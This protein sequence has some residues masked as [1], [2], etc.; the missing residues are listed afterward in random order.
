M[1]PRSAPRWGRPAFVLLWGLLI[2]CGLGASPWQ[3]FT[4]LALSPDGQSF[5]TGGREGEVL[6]W[7]TSTG[8]LLYRWLQPHEGPVIGLAFNAAGSQLGVALLD[9]SI[10]T[11]EA[12]S[13]SLR[14]SAGTSWPSLAQ[15]KERWLSSGPLSFPVRVTAGGLW[16]EGS[17]EGLIRV[18]IEGTSAPLVSWT[19]HSAA[20]TGLALADDGS[21]LLSCSYDGGLSR[22][23]PRSGN[24]LGT[25]QSPH[26]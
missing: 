5:A 22:W 15:A 25:L 21:F 13:P 20:V 26:P 17:P 12:A 19:A 24:L 7:E 11:A 16:A 23:D 8:E 18:G 14:P 10:A 2:L 3:G 4:A 9:G 1:R 6:W